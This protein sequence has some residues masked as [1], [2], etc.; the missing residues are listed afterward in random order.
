M[1]SILDALKKLEEEKAREAAP[2][3]AALD[4]RTAAEDLFGRR[5]KRREFSGDLGRHSGVPISI[6]VS[7]VLVTAALTTVFFATRTA[8]REHI[9]P[10]QDVA[11]APV[12]MQ[13][14]G[15]AS[16][17]VEEGVRSSLFVPTPTPEPPRAEPAPD[18]GFV[19]ETS[20]FSSRPSTPDKPESVDFPV[21]VREVPEPTPPPQKEFPQA[22]A[23]T[24]PPVD[25]DPSAHQV[26]DVVTDPTVLPILTP[27]EQERLG[28]P[29]LKVNF[30]SQASSTRPHP[31]A[32]INYNK[33]YLG[34][35]VPN[36]NA[37][38]IG[39]SVQGVGIDVDG[40]R[41]FVPAR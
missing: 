9:M 1:S 15:T 32:L 23:G 33:V 3:D 36:T 18:E 22:P 17:P 2:P 37:R 39:V 26:R 25:K 27:S 14:V 29:R 28:L 21:Y 19:P 10:R 5:R 4:E 16:N 11:W 7:A 40:R 38:I 34:E 12:G 35:P 24:Y 31:Y 13:A 6:A 20:S 30:V 41:Y 8:P